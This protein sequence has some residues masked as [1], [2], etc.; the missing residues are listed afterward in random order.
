MCRALTACLEWVRISGS[1]SYANLP[2]A[3]AFDVRRDES[4]PEGLGAR[5]L[6]IAGRGGCG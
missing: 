5:R 2:V 6:R 4:G 3:A 1:W